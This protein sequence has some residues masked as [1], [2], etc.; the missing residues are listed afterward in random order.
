[1]DNYDLSSSDDE[2]TFETP[3]KK[4]FIDEIC[5]DNEN[6]IDNDDDNS[7]ISENQES[8]T[9]EWSECDKNSKT[10]SIIKF[11]TGKKLPGPQV[12]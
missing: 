4:T 9:V 7:E 2:F 1:M 10:P 11:D 6:D 3:V 12:N 8:D 5:D